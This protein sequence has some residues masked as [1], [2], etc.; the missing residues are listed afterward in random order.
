MLV[1]VATSEEDETDDGNS[2]TAVNGWSGE[3]AEVRGDGD[4]GIVLIRSTDDA[5]PL[6][7]KKDVSNDASTSCSA[8]DWTE[9]EGWRTEES[10]EKF[11]TVAHG[12]GARG[13]TDDEVCVNDDKLADDDIDSGLDNTTLG[14]ITNVEGGKEDAVETDEKPSEDGVITDVE[15][16]VES[17]KVGSKLRLT[18]CS[19]A[20]SSSSS[21]EDKE[22][23]GIWK[24][25]G[26]LASDT[27][28]ELSNGV[29]IGD[30][31]GDADGVDICTGSSK[32]EGEDSEEREEI[33]GSEAGCAGIEDGE[34]T[35]TVAAEGDSD[36]G[37]GRERG[38]DGTEGADGREGTDGVEGTY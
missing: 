7:R 27:S 32:G 19:S 30:N 17:G 20:E 29:G 4:P 22:V 3:G 26:V 11:D 6:G 33:E 15:P 21:C 36:G 24:E 2:G 10:Y 23:V 13:R 14:E 25:L 31:A 1:G 16:R 12:W 9:G 35:G 34:E 8:I 5:D 37:R 28:T 38:T 18:V